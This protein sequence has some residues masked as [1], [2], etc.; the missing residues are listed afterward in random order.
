MCSITS[1][2]PQGRIS[3]TYQPNPRCFLRISSSRKVASS[4]ALIISDLSGSETVRFGACIHCPVFCLLI[5]E[6]AS[7]SFLLM[8]GMAAHSSTLAWEMP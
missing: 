6:N 7:I 1:E 3:Y 4:Q 2:Y 8:E 5:R